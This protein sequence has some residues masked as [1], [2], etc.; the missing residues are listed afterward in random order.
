MK[1][2]RTESRHRTQ[3]AGGRQSSAMERH[4]DNGTSPF[5]PTH[6]ATVV[7]VGFRP[8]PDIEAAPAA[9]HLGYLREERFIIA[10][11]HP[12]ADA[13]IWKDGR[14]SGFG[15]GG[16]DYYFYAILPVAEE[17]QA[18]LTDQEH[19]G[20]DVL[21]LDRQSGIIYIAPRLCAEEFLATAIGLEPPQRRCMCARP[22]GGAVD[23]TTC[24]AFRRKASD[25][26]SPESRA[27]GGRP[28]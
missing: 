23:C 5:N 27:A 26:G 6:A 19:I 10:A 1:E 24:P 15:E 22:L 14:Q 11:Y 7:P 3:H 12:E 18:D 28:V 8:L 25:Q 17:L 13:V 4:T 21:V 20:Q 9:H 16:W 2:V